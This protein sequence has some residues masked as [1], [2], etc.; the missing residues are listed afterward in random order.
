MPKGLKLK[1][2]EFQGLTYTFVEVTQ[3]K[4]GKGDFFSV[5]NRGNDY[6]AFIECSNDMG[7][8]YNDIEE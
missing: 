5:L 8:I 4:T 6:K 2:R 1:V 3:G 7:D